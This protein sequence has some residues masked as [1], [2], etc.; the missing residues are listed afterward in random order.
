MPPDSV[1]G[2]GRVSSS[3]A[4]A[5]IS[6]SRVR[7]LWRCMASEAVVVAVAEAAGD[8]VVELDQAVDGFGPP[9]LG[10]PVSK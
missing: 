7:R 2:I 8:A 5:T 6:R 3:S 1:V 9:L 4:A 10:P